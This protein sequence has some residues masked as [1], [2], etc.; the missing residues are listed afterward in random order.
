VV[1][2]NDRR[3]VIVTLIQLLGNRLALVVLLTSSRLQL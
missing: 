2:L 3:E 1:L